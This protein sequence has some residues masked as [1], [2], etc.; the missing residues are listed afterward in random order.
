MAEDRARTG[1]LITTVG[2]ALL[3]VSVFQPWYAL[4]LT[5]SGA[6]SAQQTLNSLALQYGDSALQGQAR[7]VDSALGAFAGHQLATLSAQQTLSHL[8]V[9]LLILAAAAFVAGLSRL[10]GSSQS[11]QASGGQIALIGAIA[12][13]CVLF[14]MLDTR[15]AEQEFVSLSLSWGIWLA[16]GSCLAV[17]AGG[18]WPAR[19]TPA[20]PSTASLQK[21]WDGLS[22]WTPEG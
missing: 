12:T 16:L 4:T 1:A 8:H 18:V 10:A 13:V 20:S 3:A 15:I 21:A 6:A 7:G 9:V 11:T 14:R 2:G 22:G 19:P 5:A 17:I